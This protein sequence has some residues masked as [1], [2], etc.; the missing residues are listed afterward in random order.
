MRCFHLC[1]AAFCLLQLLA[2]ATAVASGTTTAAAAG[3]TTAAAAG[4]TTA[5]VPATTP[6]TTPS[7]SPPTQASDILCNNGL[8]CRS[9]SDSL[10][11]CF[12][13]NMSSIAVY[14]CRCSSAQFLAPLCQNSAAQLISI[15]AQA[16]QFNGSLFAAQFASQQES[17]CSPGHSLCP[18]RPPAASV[19][20]STSKKQLEAEKD[21]LLTL[22]VPMLSFYN[23]C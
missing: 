17:K 4:T 21:K 23:C 15:N 1:P 22:Q 5:A 3:T 19:Q 14:T 12:G 2:F 16:Q 8:G 10:A 20:Q 7:P 6:P 9:Q 11:L 13:S 18:P